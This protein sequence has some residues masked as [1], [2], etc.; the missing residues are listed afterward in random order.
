M[1][2][3]L[4]TTLQTFTK[5]PRFRLTPPSSHGNIAGEMT[6]SEPEPSSMAIVRSSTARNA[7]R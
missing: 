6:L 4:M 1:S 3:T 5:T 7:Q 2:E